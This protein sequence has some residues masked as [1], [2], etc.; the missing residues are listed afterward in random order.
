MLRDFGDFFADHGECAG[1]G[2]RRGSTDTGGW[3][4]NEI[5]SSVGADGGG[6]GALMSINGSAV[7]IEVAGGIATS[8]V[9]S[10]VG[11]ETERDAGG[12]T[13]I[14]M[15]VIAKLVTSG[16]AEMPKPEPK[17]A[18]PKPADPSPD[19]SERVGVG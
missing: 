12:T 13:A 14:G 11:S 2:E 3:G 17:P 1:R 5:K 8:I 16:D 7:A 19:W 18:D 9:T 6:T 4:E 15:G 10:G